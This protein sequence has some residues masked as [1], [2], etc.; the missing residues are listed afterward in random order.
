MPSLRTAVC[1]RRSI[2][3]VVFL[4]FL[5]SLASTDTVFAAEEDATPN[6]ATELAPVVVTADR[7]P[8]SIEE[9]T[10]PIFVVDRQEIVDQGA[11]TAL[12]A[13]R[14]VPGVDVTSNGAPGDD[15]DIHLLGTDRDEVLVLID[16]VPINTVLDNRPTI[17]GTI[18]AS[19]VERIEVIEGA[20]TGMYGS[21][22]V[23]GVINII[24]RTGEPGIYGDVGFRGGNLGTFIEDA[25]TSGGAGNHRWRLHYQRWDQYGRFAHDRTAQ[26]ALSANW[27]YDFSDELDV[28]ISP[29]Y[30]NTDQ[31]LAFDAVAEGPIFYFPRDT[32]RALRRDTVVV[33]I[34]L[35]LHMKPWWESYFDY[36]YYYQHVR[37]HNPPT[38]DV[39]PG[40]ILGDQFASSSEDRHRISFRNVFIPLDHQ[41]YRD[42]FTVGFDVDV[43]HL[44]FLNGPSGGPHV[45][46]P[47]PGQKFDRQNYAVF[48]QNVFHLKRWLILSAGMRYDDNSMFGHA[49]TARASVATHIAPS[50]TT[51]KFNYAETFNAPLITLYVLGIQ[52][53]KETA[54]NYSAGV[55]QDLWGKGTL[56]SFF[57][58]SDYDSFFSDGADPVGTN[59]AYAMSVETTLKLRPL[60]WLRFQGSYTWTRARDE[61]RNVPL[62]ER[63]AHTWK[64]ML[65][66]EPIK[67]L[68][69]QAD[70]RVVGERHWGT[71]SN[72]IFVDW[73]GNVSD[74]TLD[75]YTRLDLAGHYTFSFPRILQ[76]LRL[77][78]RVANVLNESYQEKFGHPAPGVNFLI[79]FSGTFGGSID[80]DTKAPTPESGRLEPAGSDID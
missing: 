29:Q 72:F 13:L 24:T 74:G 28:S 78:A 73:Q 69:F 47:L 22:A 31:E 1:R 48:L 75:R 38:G 50:G 41:G 23:G 62:P 66:V 36:S 9:V 80:D 21:R 65:T 40:T 16:G 8:Q 35:A 53:Q 11:Q 25:G 67:H 12:D 58:Y 10:S 33:P 6:E 51:V 63:P 46:F 70:L 57:F 15:N 27:R 49:L 19:T 4:L 79:G 59:D 76:D 2:V 30:F 34:Q 55:E 43:E 56:S 64:A 42:L 18:P 54:Q 60:R 17:L 68:V 32:N 45:H 37:L 3:R 26:N 71:N 77:S 5:S 7:R 14:T 44:G 61:V 39:T 52:P 20:Q